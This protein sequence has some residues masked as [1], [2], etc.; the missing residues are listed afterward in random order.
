[1]R[2][3]ERRP[4]G[5]TAMQQCFNCG[6]VNGMPVGTADPEEIQ[7]QHAFHWDEW[8]D[9]LECHGCGIKIEGLAVACLR[10]MGKQEFTKKHDELVKSLNDVRSEN[11]EL[12]AENARLRRKVDG[13]R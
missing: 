2:K 11:T 13:P 9:N 7:C 5:F 3:F 1:M 8:C 10:V 4:E 6:V 12:L